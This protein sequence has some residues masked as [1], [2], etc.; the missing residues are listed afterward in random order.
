MRYGAWTAGQP[1]ACVICGATKTSFMA[2]PA[3]LGELPELRVR[4]LDKSGSGMD[5]SL[6]ATRWKDCQRGLS[7]G[8]R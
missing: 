5:F 7:D 2:L 6:C 3:G 8:A 1:Y 4:G